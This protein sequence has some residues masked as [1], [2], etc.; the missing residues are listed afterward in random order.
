MGRIPINH[1]FWDPLTKRLIKQVTKHHIKQIKPRSNSKMRSSYSKLPSIGSK[2]S[3]ICG[4]RFCKRTILIEHIK[5]CKTASVARYC[6]LCCTVCPDRYALEAHQRQAHGSE[7]CI[8]CGKRFSNATVLLKHRIAKH[9]TLEC[10]LCGKKYNIQRN[11][12]R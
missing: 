1:T 7:P 6:R 2:L 4:M 10:N 5:I 9:A 12:N 3:C 8:D 11:L